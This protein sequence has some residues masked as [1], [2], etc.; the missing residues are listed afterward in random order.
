MAKATEGYKGHRPGVAK[1]DVHKMFDTKGK[2]A[3]IALAEKLKLAKGTARSWI[4][5]WGGKGK[6]AVAKKTAKKAAKKTVAKKAVAKKASVPAQ[7]S[8]S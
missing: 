7:A 3:A 5:S 2:D 8:A 4:S 6:K 1:G